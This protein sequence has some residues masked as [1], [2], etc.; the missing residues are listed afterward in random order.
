MFSIVAEAGETSTVILSGIDDAGGACVSKRP[1]AIMVVSAKSSGMGFFVHAG[2]T[3]L[4]L[5]FRL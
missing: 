4:G 3:G 1:G 5:G 2:V